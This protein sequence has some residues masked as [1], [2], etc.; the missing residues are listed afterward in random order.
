M[1]NPR[2]AV[3]AVLVLGLGLAACGSS[4]DDTKSAATSTT[5][6]TADPYDVYLAHNPDPSLVL[7]REDAQAR[8]YLGCGKQW[9]PGT[10]DRALADA[11]AASVCRG[12]K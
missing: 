11:Y 2:T 5:A 12:E 9:A 8:A 6:A 3:A 10:I 1:R 4:G 7:S